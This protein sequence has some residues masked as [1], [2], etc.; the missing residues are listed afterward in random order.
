MFSAHVYKIV[1]S[2]SVQLTKID[3]YVSL[4]KQEFFMQFSIL[5]GVQSSIRKKA[6]S[7]MKIKYFR[8]DANQI[9]EANKSYACIRV[10]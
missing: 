6:I 10:V 9:P 8:L 5:Q 4:S 2:I 1:F 3:L 7:D